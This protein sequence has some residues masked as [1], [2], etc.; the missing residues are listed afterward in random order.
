LKRN[1]PGANLVQ[2][3][4]KS[5]DKPRENAGYPFTL[6]LSRTA[7]ER[8]LINMATS[9]AMTE[10]ESATRH[11]LNMSVDD[12]PLEPTNDNYAYG[13]SVKMHEPA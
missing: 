2:E 6:A 11:E 4:E 7:E 3:A 5:E 9:Q 13:E 8:N 1:K 10:T 12:Y